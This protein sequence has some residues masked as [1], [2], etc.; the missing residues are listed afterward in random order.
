MGCCLFAILIA[1]MPRFAFLLWW[2][3]QPVRMNATFDTFLWPLIGVIFAPWTTIMYVLVFPAG[4]S[5]FDWVWLA[6]A[7]FIDIGTY[8]GNWR[9]RGSMSAGT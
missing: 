3:F 5:G 4:I 1:G 6:L 8:A 7:A 9:A 2:L